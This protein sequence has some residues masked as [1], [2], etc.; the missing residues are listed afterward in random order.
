[1]G[2]RND[3]K[4][5]MMTVEKQRAHDEPELVDDAQRRK[6]VDP[7]SSFHLEAP[8]GSGKTYLLTA[9]FLRLL[10]IVEHPQQIL[11]LTF[12]NKAA[13]E[14]KERVGRTLQRAARGEKP[15]GE[16]D[17]EMLDCAARALRRHAKVR[18]LLLGGDLLL[19]Q[20]FHSFCYS[21]VS[22]APLEALALPGSTLLEEEKQLTILRESVEK[23]LLD[24]MS[25]SPED[26]SRRAFENRLLYLNNSWSLLARELEELMRRRDAL[27][28]TI[29]VL[30]RQKTSDYVLHGI[31]E[32]AESELAAL[33]SAFAGSALGASWTEFQGDLAAHSAAAAEELPPSLPGPDWE[34]LPAWQS[35]AE[36]LLTKAGEPKKRFGPSNGFYA[37][38]A[39]T[40]WFALI[41][42]LGPQTA[43]RLHRTR[44]LPERESAFP[45]L[46]TLWDLILLLHEVMHV[47]GERCR[48]E[49]AMD[50]TELE[51]AALRLFDDVTPSDLQLLLD[52]RIQHVLVDEFQD[53]SRKQWE[54]LRKLCAGWS[55]QDGRTLFVVGDPKQ[56]IYGFRKAEVQLF[57]EARA[58]LPLDGGE[59]LPL[60]SLTL[61]TNF[62][63]A[64]P[65]I[66]WC[67]D[68]FEKSIMADH[69]PELDEVPFTPSEPSPS[70]KARGGSPAHELALF[71]PWPDRR[72][73][74]ERE[75]EWLACRLS[76]RLEELGPETSVGI[77]LFTRT[78]L[79]IY[80]EALQ[81]KGIP[82]QV[83]QGLKLG[84]RPEVLYLWQLCRALVLPQ[85]HLAW[86]AQLRSPWLCLNYD[87]MLAVSREK[88][89]PWVEKIRAH[90]EGDEKLA[91]FWD[92]LREARRHLGHE[93]LADVL[94]TAWLDLGAA[95]A[96][97]GRWG[98]RGIACCRRFFDLLRQ[99]E[100]AEPVE[101]LRQLE[102]LMENAFE[103]VDP[104]TAVSRVSMMTVHR[105]KG[106]E[107]DVVYLP[108]LDWNP[109]SRERKNQPP[110]LLERVPGGGE[111]HLLAARPDQRRG[112]PDPVYRRLHRLLVDRR[113][114]EAK[115]LFYVA[116]TRARSVLHLSGVVS[117]SHGAT[118]PAFPDQTPLAWLDGHYGLSEGLGFDR[119]SSPADGAVECPP[120]W[121]VTWEA[122]DR[123]FQVCV[124]PRTGAPAEVALPGTQQSEE[125][126]A[127]PFE[128]ERPAYSLSQPS[129]LFS[130][131]IAAQGTGEESSGQR[132]ARLWGTLIHRLLKT[133]GQR[134]E[135]PPEEGILGFLAS[136]GIDGTQAQEWARTALN[137]A[138]LCARD[139]WLGRLY[140]VPENARFV[141]WGLEGRHSERTIYSG[142]LDLVA[143]CE[144][145]WWLVDFKTSKP[146]VG[147]TFEAFSLRELKKYSPQLGAYREMWS[148][149]RDG[150]EGT[151]ETVLYWTALRRWERC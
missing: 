127:A 99:A 38:F 56:S 19:I 28:D 1:M 125:V 150:V 44:E 90:A 57:T 52:H 10:G 131:I 81:R 25:R 141:E 60:E 71:V 48:S 34:S 16:L 91:V 74:R 104:D 31:R 86:A 128:R 7:A 80:L 2:K 24:I 88:P 113:W 33:K 129:S 95:R 66:E 65:L 36:A 47:Y 32:L 17:A 101:T 9:R 43:D 26:P 111:R 142:A 102:R 145:T 41:Q 93:P 14:M 85:D 107:F 140:A 42:D 132:H 112:K 46:D 108:F 37:G 139:A 12:T 98:S 59:R 63:S 84:E 147:E 49:C 92:N 136:N 35:V 82:V 118:L 67:N 54:L 130:D 27:M 79:S 55:A 58:G 23:A 40:S 51:M 114:G 73:A 6:A 39:K 45:D 123:P 124:E 144:G 96:V 18:E 103:P 117:L 87:E 121:S 151:V 13:G 72:S 106:L 22:K 122:E 137:E 133:Y 135:F 3:L 75:A 110:F 61:R 8:A 15:N 5:G 70:Q 149:S 119:F 120:D 146:A 126:A 11:A 105:A 69:V 83:E 148:K 138:G 109:V 53:T 30:D 89:E 68:L 116:A 97:A 100:A 20:T 77:L 50:F 143:F 134:K 21:L 64:P 115:R 62:R 76:R 94:E 29:E 78:H 4:E